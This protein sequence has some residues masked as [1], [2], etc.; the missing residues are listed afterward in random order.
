LDAESHKHELNPPA[1]AENYPFKTV[2][3]MAPGGLRAPVV[4]YLC[5]RAED[6]K[7]DGRYYEAMQLADLICNL[8]P[9]FA[10][11]WGFHGWNMAYNISVQTHTPEER[12]RW[13]YGGIELLRDRGIP[14][15]PKSLNLYRE[16]GWIF[17]HK[18]GHFMDDMHVSYKSRL[19]ARM[20]RLLASPPYGTTAET[21]EAFRPIQQ[22]PL[23]RDPRRQGQRDI[24]Q[25]QLALVA[26][27]PAVE[28]YLKLLDQAGLEV[29]W[30]LLDAY[31]R[32][33]LDEQAEM[34]RWAP[35]ALRTDRDKLLSR[36]MNDSR[37]TDARLK[38]LA[39]AR[40]QILWNAYRMDPDWMMQLM[41]KY[42]PID[43]RLPMAHAVYWTTYGLHICE[44]T[45]LGDI[46]SLNTDRIVLNALK[47]MTWHGRLTY[48]EN[49]QNPEMP[50]ITWGSDWRFIDSTQ[51]EFILMGEATA[52]A[53]ETDFKD[54]QLAI[55]HINY[56]SQSIQMLYI[57]YRRQKAAD[58][59][60]YI[61]ETF[62]PDG[63][64]WSLGLEDF[65]VDQ[66]RRDGQPSQ[67]SAYANIT[68]ALKTA[69]VLRALGDVD[70]YRRSVSLAKRIYDAY[71]VDVPRR[72]ALPPM[73]VLARDVV[74]SLLVRPRVLGVD[75]AL[76][77]RSELYRALDDGMQREL[78]DIIAPA[79][80]R[81][82]DLWELDFAKAFPAPPG[83]EQARQR[84]A[85]KL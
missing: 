7:N 41:D 9:N 5:I 81:Q 49:P 56:L 37:H 22:A 8:V 73:G 65:V 42:G 24:Q 31:N 45:E 80:R 69:F 20:Q 44:A 85:P 78:Y 10:G 58:L 4:S 62:D 27:E 59:L 66:F 21:L 82:C 71:T 84:R 2:F 52:K 17:Y 38:L 63:P 64:E 70:G 30:Q 12:W 76:V 79:L 61:K 13:V 40:A 72:I 39:F 29:G 47:S 46:N 67:D 23:D 28:Q 35:P 33:S 36:L 16:L 32:Y 48:V 54:S 50:F 53:R 74:A 55:G 60:E 11:V 68:T 6:L 15:N 26:S 1:V 75:L 83:M 34:V 14:Q 43:W 19:A 51:K 25:D 77:K 57:G 18:M 3:T